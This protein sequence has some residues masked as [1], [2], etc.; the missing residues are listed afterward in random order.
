MGNGLLPV[1]FGFAVFS[2]GFI[3]VG[4]FGIGVIMGFFL[5]GG[6]FFGAGFL[7]GAVFFLGA[8][9]VAVGANRST[10]M[11]VEGEDAPL[12]KDA[13]PLMQDLNLGKKV[14]FDWAVEYLISGISEFFEIILIPKDFNAEEK[15]AILKIQKEQYENSEWTFGGLS[16]SNL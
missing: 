7:L 8:V 3:E 16:G 2:P 1:D 15:E 11:G 5:G 6:F 12:V 4:F 9:F 14:S 10:A 13:L